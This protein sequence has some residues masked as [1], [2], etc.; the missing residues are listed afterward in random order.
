[1]PQDGALNLSIDDLTKQALATPGA[2]YVKPTIEKLRKIEGQKE[3]AEEPTYQQL[4]KDVER[5]KGEVAKKYEG[6][7]PTDLKPWT[8]KMPE[9]DPLEVFG[10]MG[11]VFGILASAFTHTP[12]VNALNASAAAMNAIKSNDEKAYKTAFDA[13]KENTKL[14]LDRHKVEYDDYRAAVDKMQTDMSAGD[15]MLRVYA[16]KY[17][18]RKAEVMAE[19]GLLKDLDQAQSAKHA[20]AMQMLGLYPQ[21]EKAGEQRMMLMAD[22]DW[23]S[24]DPQ[25]MRIA[26]QRTTQA[27][28]PYGART[29]A[30]GAQEAEMQKWHEQ[31]VQENGREPS[32]DEELGARQKISEAFKAPGGGGNVIS[33]TRGDAIKKQ[34][35]EWQDQHPGETMSGKQEAAIVND[36]IKGG[37]TGNL[38]ERL[39]ARVD[40]IGYSMQKLDSTISVLDRYAFAAGAPGMA[41][42]LGERL[43]DL[44]GSNKTDRVQFMRD[45]ELLQAMAP[46]ILL[47]ASGRPLSGEAERIKDIIGGLKFGDTTANTKRSLED[48]KR[49]YDQMRSDTERRMGSGAGEPA[50]PSEPA[51]PAPAPAPKP[52]RWQDAPLAPQ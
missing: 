5:D 31:F 24:G 17:G 10:S 47:D 42:R 26:M 35:K 18:D 19:A 49:L 16:A 33:S 36:V 39:Q 51:V 43:E 32:F 21:L 34:I 7:E 23:K 3:S 28:S 9:R 45:L 20:A 6:I 25:R 41:T 15:A 29:T 44:F 11:S 27:M 12:M 13:W 37:I 14:A 50:T 52:Q 46:R 40:Q 8:Q 30:A 4:Q 2:S 22:P 48:I 38:S 1:M